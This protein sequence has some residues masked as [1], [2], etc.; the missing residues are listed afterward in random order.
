MM[1][2]IP[3]KNER[4]VRDRKSHAL[5][6]IDHDAVAAYEKQ[7]HDMKAQ[8]DRI[9]RLEQEINELKKLLSKLIEKR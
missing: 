6:S 9:N 7:K 3:V 8:K 5:L 2:R 1:D 4:M